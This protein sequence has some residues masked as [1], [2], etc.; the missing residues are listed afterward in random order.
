MN[1][2]N[3]KKKNIQVLFVVF[4]N[5]VS[6]CRARQ[7]YFSVNGILRGEQQKNVS[8]CIV[9]NDISQSTWYE[10]KNKNKKEK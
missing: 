1:N 9:S 8:L 3:N 6:F 7:K 5:Y 4:V 10:L 2:N